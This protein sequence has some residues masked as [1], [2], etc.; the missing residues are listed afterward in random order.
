[1]AQS[2]TIHWGGVASTTVPGLVVGKVTRSLLG[3]NRGTHRLVGGRK[4]S[5]F[6]GQPPGTRTVRAE[7][8]IESATFEDRRAALESLADWLDITTEAKLRISDEPGVYYK[9]TLGSIPDPDEWREFSTFDLEWICQPYAFDTSTT[10]ES[11]TSDTDDTHT[12]DPG[13]TVDVEPVIEV[14]PTDGTLTSFRVTTNNKQMTINHTVSSGTT[15]TINGQAM[16]VTTGADTDT[17]VVGAYNPANLVVS[18]VSGRFPTLISGGNN[19]IR[20]QRLSGTATQ[21]SIKVIFRK[22]YRK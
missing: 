16:N 6:F 8:F 22:Q 18:P 7:C 5:I 19:S 11:W 17:E 1:M 20:F 10:L 12:W 15:I 4:G 9:A 21:I 13:L 3:S 14:R 2:K